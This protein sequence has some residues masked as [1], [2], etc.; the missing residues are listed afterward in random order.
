MNPKDPKIDPKYTQNGLKKFE[1]KK[2]GPK[3][4]RNGFKMTYND[5]NP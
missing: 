2:F 4:T 1:P 3:Y 5:S